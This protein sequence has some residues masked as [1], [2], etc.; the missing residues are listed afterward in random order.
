MRKITQAVVTV[1]LVGT[2]CYLWLTGG[3]VPPGLEGAGGGALV[4]LLRDKL[5]GGKA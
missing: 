5:A 3:A 4:W 2:C 1:G